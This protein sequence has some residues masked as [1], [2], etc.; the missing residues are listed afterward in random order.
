MLLVGSRE[1]LQ[2]HML[3]DLV[4]NETPEHNAEAAAETWGRMQ[5][6]G[7]RGKERQLQPQ[8]KQNSNT[9]KKREAL[10][11]LILWQRRVS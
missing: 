6:E 3:F 8:R 2:G 5:Q 11:R 10:L 1:A 9:T 4:G 7:K